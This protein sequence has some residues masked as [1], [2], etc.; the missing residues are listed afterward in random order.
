MSAESCWKDF[1]MG[2]LNLTNVNNSEKKWLQNVESVCVTLLL[3]W[4]FTSSICWIQLRH[5]GGF[6]Q[7]FQVTTCANIIMGSELKCFQMAL[8]KHI[9]E[10]LCSF[11]WNATFKLPGWSG[12]TRTLVLRIDTLF[13]KHASPNLL[14]RF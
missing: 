8:G 6:L 11:C 12:S 7:V 14:V 1:L 4:P 3:A 10:M 9:H 5:E 2:L 13:L